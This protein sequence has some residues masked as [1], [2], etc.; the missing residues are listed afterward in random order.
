MKQLILIFTISIF[1]ISCSSEDENN[2]DADNLR[3]Y[4][5]Q[6]KELNEKISDIEQANNDK[7]YS[8]IKIPVKLESLSLRPFSHNFTAVGEL[9]S[10][11]DA[12]IS[13][14]INGQ[15]TSVYVSEGQY[16]QKGQLLAKLNT[17]IIETNIQEI[18]SQLS[19][20]KTIYEKQSS[21]WEKNIGSERQYLEAK[22]SFENLQ[23][24]LSTLKAQYDLAII[25]S[26]INGI[27]EEI[28]HKKG[29]LATPGMQLMQ[30]VNIDELYVTVK[31]S[32]AYLPII[33]KGDIVTISFP[34]YPGLEYRKPVYRTGN[35]INKQDRTFIVQI[36]IANKNG[37]LKP[38]LQAN[39]NINDYNIDNVI[40]LP[41]ILIK[42]DMTGSFIYIVETANGKSIATKKY[43]KTGISYKDKT[44]ILDGLSAGD[45]IITDGYSNVSNGSVVNVI[46]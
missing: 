29:E 43:I 17:V 20:A 3:L 16:V 4:K 6:V 44:E 7:E 36:K 21:L 38:H 5:T 9:E 22:N 18:E 19:L 2:S 33:K 34:A 8:G 1:I 10:I 37:K 46:Q 31:L 42:E 11:N 13:P 45:M 39:V 32:E 28:F 12:F 35:V 30:I 14:E 24:K 40:V 23:N 25:K 41:T 15:I 27:V 26:P